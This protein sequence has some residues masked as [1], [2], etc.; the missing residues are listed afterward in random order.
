MFIRGQ[1]IALALLLT[2]AL[3]SAGTWVIQGWRSEAKI[4]TLQAD[5]AKVLQAQARAVVESVEA[6]R[7]LGEQ[8]AAA[9]E[10]ERDHAI[11]QNEA[12]AVDLAG[13]V[14]ASNRLRS[15]LAKLRA[16]NASILAATAQRGEGQSSDDPIGV[17]IGMYERLD[18]AGR[19]ISEYADRLRVAGLSCERTYDAIR[20]V[21]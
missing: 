14:V 19:G 17:L 15:E 16:R 1:I 9:V 12:L 4:A 2:A 3:A 8:R 11:E 7:K 13:N 20:R 5:H 21:K 6:A 10:N 18:D